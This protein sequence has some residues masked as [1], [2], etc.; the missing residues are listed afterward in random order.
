[1]AELAR[2][3]GVAKGTL[4][5]YFE[6]R[7]EVF[8]ALYVDQI[9]RWGEVFTTRLHRGMS[10]ET[11]A[12]AFI[13]TARGDPNM[14]PLLLRLDHVIEHNVS[15][16]KLILSKRALRSLLDDIA[17]PVAQALDLDAAQAFDAISS[18]ASL[19][20]GVCR[21]DQGPEIEDEELPDDVRELMDA[22]STDERF[23]TNARRILAGIRSGI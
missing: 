13:E 15:T 1:M 20:L 22:F 3:A 9:G 12:H 19:M 7:E 18:L 11:F 4:Y 6:T 8:L 17:E 10:D 23:I 5:L 2:L 14:I 21:G 16:E